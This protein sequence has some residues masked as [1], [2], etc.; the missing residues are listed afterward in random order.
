MV[1]SFRQSSNNIDLPVLPNNCDTPVELIKLILQNNPILIDNW[2]KVLSSD[3]L[4]VD[5]LYQFMFHKNNWLLSWFGLQLLSNSFKIWMI[6]NDN[7]LIVNGS[8]LTYMGRI[9]KSPWYIHGRY[10]II[11][12]EALHFELALI[13]G[14]I[15]E[16]VLLFGS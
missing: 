14:D 15:K 8:M 1:K 9:I 2:K 4:S 11:F 10:I 6:P 12:N 3:V 13:D 7:N 5:K 16:Y